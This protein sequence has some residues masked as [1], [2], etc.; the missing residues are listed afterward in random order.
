[1]GAPRLATA[2]WV[3]DWSDEWIPLLSI[4]ALAVCISDFTASAAVAWVQ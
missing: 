2:V 1:M 4:D 3:M